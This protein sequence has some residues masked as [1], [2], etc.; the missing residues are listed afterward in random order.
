LYL[1]KS[2]LQAVNGASPGQSDYAASPAQVVYPSTT[3]TQPTE[4]TKATITL[5]NNTTA[6]GG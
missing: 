5:N 3:S 2:T 1:D 6:P 4:K